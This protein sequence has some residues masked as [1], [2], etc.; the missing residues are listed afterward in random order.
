[1]TPEALLNL[2]CKGLPKVG[3]IIEQ[4]E[5]LCLPDYLE[6]L[7]PGAGTPSYQPMKD[8]LE[9]VYQYI[10]PLLGQ[11]AAKMAVQDLEAH[12]VVLTASH[13][14]VEYFPQTFQGRLI[15]SLLALKKK[16]S[17]S[18]LITFACGNIPL[19]NAVFPR[20]A[21]ISQAGLENIDHLSG[22]LPIFPDRLKRSIVSAAPA[23]D[24]EMLDRAGARFS[25][26]A[27]GQNIPAGVCDALDF[28]LEEIYKNSSVLGLSSYSDQSVVV[29]HLIWK[30]IFKGMDN[31]P[32]S[33]CL[34]FE[35]IA[36]RLLEFDLFNPQSLAGLILFDPNLRCGVLAELDGV[37]GCWSLNPHKQQRAVSCK[38][39][40]QGDM[41]SNCGT[42]FFWGIDDTGRKLSLNLEARGSGIPSFFGLDDKGRS[43]EW[44]C[45]PESLQTGISE[46]RLIPSMFLCF[47]VL[48]FARGLTCI[49]GYFQGEYL[50]AMQKGLARALG[51]S[52][53]YETLAGFI[54]QART[55]AYLDGMLAVMARVG[56]H[57]VPAGP[58]ELA[59]GKGMILADMDR[60]SRLTVREAHLADLFDT[61]Q[62]ALPANTLPHGWK[63]QL[64]RD[65]FRSLK[66]KV[67][68]K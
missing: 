45:T 63:R 35:K 14:G 50:P 44:P 5:D 15:F 60:L 54:A 32:D 18:T 55:D 23:F 30:L 52:R 16:I 3:R 1:M 51:K 36:G 67:V 4:Y 40:K 28:I 27:K 13:F 42:V 10:E 66:D 9:V 61:L 43:R 12:P 17:A 22:R 6:T 64:A 19:N 68:M 8:L 25:R 41:P 59:A 62:D 65:T 37:S 33:I 31:A 39:E 49:G 57:L 2:A 58:L 21:L 7:V 11:D 29:N 53:K 48:L 38:G 56:D 26:M 47:A 20:G 34:E 24:R 46:G